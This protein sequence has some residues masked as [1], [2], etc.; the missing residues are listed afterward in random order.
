MDRKILT[1]TSRTVLKNQD[2]DGRI[3]VGASRR[4]IAIA[5]LFDINFQSHEYFDENCLEI[6]T[7]AVENVQLKLIRPL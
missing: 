1:G 5:H 6:S 3:I 7:S 4:T 2:K